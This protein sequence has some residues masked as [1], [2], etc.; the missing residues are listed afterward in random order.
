MKLRDT[1]RIPVR[2]S[3]PV[4]CNDIHLPLERQQF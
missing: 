2:A 1:M 3:E 4:I